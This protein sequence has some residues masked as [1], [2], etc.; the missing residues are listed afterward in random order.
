MLDWV[1]LHEKPLPSEPKEVARILLLNEC[2]TDVEQVLNEYF[3]LIQGGWVNVRALSE[4]E[5]YKEKL[6]KATAAGKASGVARKNKAKQGLKP[7][8]QTLSGCSTDDEP[9]NKQELLTTKQEPSL[10]GGEICAEIVK[11]YKQNNI[12]PI[13]VSAHNPTFTKLVEANATVDEFIYAINVAISKK[14]KKPFS[15]AMEVL[16]TERDKANDLVLNKTPTKRSAVDESIRIAA[17][18][19][20]T[21]ENT[22]HLRAAINQEKEV[23]DV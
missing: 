4:I 22:K 6:E 23:T 15:Y 19:I 10:T 2:L 21:P 5:A 11:V 13:D 18:S 17:S 7:P 3:E 12:A 8:E 20:F 16:V 14:I 1:Y 9:N